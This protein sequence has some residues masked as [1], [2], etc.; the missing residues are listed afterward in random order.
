MEV[1]YE[2]TCSKCGCIENGTTEI[3]P[4]DWNDLD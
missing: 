3:E 4:Q 2:H 1:E